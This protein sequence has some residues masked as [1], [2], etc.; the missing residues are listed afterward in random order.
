MVPYRDSKL[1]R[2]FQSFFSGHGTVTMVINVSGCAT[3]FDETLHA[4]KYGALATQVRGS[5][6]LYGLW[7]NAKLVLHVPVSLLRCL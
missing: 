3:T 4:L 6:Q 1:T 5:E 7:F 2:L